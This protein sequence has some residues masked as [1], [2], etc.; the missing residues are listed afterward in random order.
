[1]ATTALSLG[2]TALPLAGKLYPELNSNEDFYRY[3]KMEKSE[4]LK[5]QIKELNKENQKY[6][7]KEKRFATASSIIKYSSLVLMGGIELSSLAI[8][9]LIPGG[10]LIALI[11][12]T[13]GGG[14]ELFSELLIRKIIGI[15]KKKYLGKWIKSKA[16]LDK[17]YNFS[18][19]AM[20]DGL[21]TDDEILECRNILNEYE[22]EKINA[23][24][25]ESSKNIEHIPKE[26]FQKLINTLQKLS[27]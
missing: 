3:L 8:G 11:F 5:K 17:V 27:K 22:N 26:D 1:M 15:E 9:F 13:S 12:G 18:N 21:I 20:I 25:N 10:G 2:D 14:L 23:K 7:R 16:C 19:K 6:K 4:S 24:S